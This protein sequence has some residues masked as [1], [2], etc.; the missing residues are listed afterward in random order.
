MKLSEIK[1][2]VAP[3]ISKIVSTYKLGSQDAERVSEFIIGERDW[4]DLSEKARTRL[5]SHYEN[6]FDADETVATDPSKFILP[7][8]KRDV[9]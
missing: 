5:Y 1:I 6:S 4:E 3:N 7:L 2:T 9:V 8:L